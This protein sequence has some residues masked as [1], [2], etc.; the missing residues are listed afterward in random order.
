MNYLKRMGARVGI[1]FAVALVISG[2]IWVF[3]RF[4]GNSD[5]TSLKVGECFLM[6]DGP[7]RG[8]GATDEMEPLDTSVEEEYPTVNCDE[9]ASQAEPWKVYRV[10]WEKKAGGTDGPTALELQEECPDI[11]IHHIN[12]NR[13]TCLANL[14]EE[15]G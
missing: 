11:S 10:E 6:T 4:D 3:D 9:W 13:V 14:E 2:G 15:A 7:D 5:S 8:S 12:D 1:V